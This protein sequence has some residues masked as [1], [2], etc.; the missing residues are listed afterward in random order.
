M[1]IAKLYGTGNADGVAMLEISKPAKIIAIH[2][3]IRQNN[4]T[5]NA[6]A[7]FELSFSSSSGFANNDTRASFFGGAIV[8]NLS[9]NGANLSSLC[10]GLASLAIPVAAGERLYLHIESIATPTAQ[11]FVSAWLY[12]GSVATAGKTRHAAR[13]LA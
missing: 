11:A 8:R 7:Q 2:A 3:V 6:G 5:T 13:R 9:T 4:L 1:D 12:L 10:F